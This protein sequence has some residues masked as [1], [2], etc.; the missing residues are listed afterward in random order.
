MRNQKSKTQSVK[1]MSRK[2]GKVVT[3]FSEPAKRYAQKLEDDPNVKSYEVNIP[4]DN[5]QQT[6]SRVGLRKEYMD[7]E[8]TSDFLII[9][10]DDSVGIRELTPERCFV[11]AAEMEKLEISRRYWKAGHVANWMIVATE[12]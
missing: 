8:W 7:V 11:K 5:W 10:Q 6:I 3:V 2:N 1:F 12:G 9:F 4:L